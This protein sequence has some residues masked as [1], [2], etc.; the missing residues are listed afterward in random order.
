M[1]TKY[2]LSSNQMVF[3]NYSSQVTNNHIGLLRGDH[4]CWVLHAHC[5]NN[6]WNNGNQEMKE[7]ASKFKFGCKYR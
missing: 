5:K 3:L 1:A 4:I 2:E 6:F 7:A